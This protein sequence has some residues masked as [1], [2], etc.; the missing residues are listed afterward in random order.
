MRIPYVLLIPVIGAFVLY[1]ERRKVV[2]RIGTTRSPVVATLLAAGAL[3][4]FG[5]LAMHILSPLQNMC[6]RS[7]W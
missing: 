6:C 1:L 3:A 7:R 2:S 4:I 5:L